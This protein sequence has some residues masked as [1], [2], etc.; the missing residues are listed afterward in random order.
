[1]D[2][3]PPSFLTEEKSNPTAVAVRSLL[4][5]FFDSSLTTFILFLPLTPVLRSRE[6]LLPFECSRSSSPADFH[7]SS[8]FVV[9]VFEGVLETYDVACEWIVSSCL[10][11]S[12]SADESPLASIVRFVSE[13]ARR[14]RTR[15]FLRRRLLFDRLLLLLW[16][17]Q[18]S[19]RLRTSRESRPPDLKLLLTSWVL[20]PSSRSC[21]ETDLVF[22]FVAFS[23]S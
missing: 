15:R 13:S 8:Q 19:S 9:L 16:F 14:T 2:L 1:M 11:V 18:R 5:L 7:C 20:R 17:H 22:V 12:S 6:C 23:F 10:D 3:S 21:S 4:P